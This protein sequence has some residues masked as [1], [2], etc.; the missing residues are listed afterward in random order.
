MRKQLPLKLNS[1]MS[2]L[3]TIKRTG[4]FSG[5]HCFVRANRFI[6]A[7]VTG[8]LTCSVAA[9]PVTDN[10]DILAR[11][12]NAFENASYDGV[13]VYSQGQDVKTL[14][15]IHKVKDGVEKERLIH[16]DG[17]RFE[18][19]RD[20]EKLSCVLPKTADG[21]VEHKVPPS[22]F[23]QSFTSNIPELK[24][25]YYI[26]EDRK[27]RFLGRETVRLSILPKQADRYSYQLWID[28]T[29]GLMLKSVLKNLSGDELERFQFSS[30]EIGKPIP[31]YLFMVEDLSQ[32][33]VVNIPK[34][35][36]AR[37]RLENKGWRVDWIPGGFSSVMND[38][39]EMTS[40][41]MGALEYMKAYSDGLFSFSVLVEKIESSTD[42]DG[43][44]TVG[45]T[46]VMRRKFTDLNNHYRVTVVGEIPVATVKRILTSV[47]Q[48]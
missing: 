31:D 46:T 40:P 11:M 16:L 47:V 38:E 24:K 36:P 2:E 29:S 25:N 13:F 35:T 7:A 12:S 18:L 10:A 19:L 9:D 26:R 17:N 37:K 28:K 42:G 41:V 33:K 8:M 27:Q 4:F 22:S 39:I 21:P 32:V 23:A 3:R 14:R 1:S 45:A 15:V 20:G 48:E 30:L 6:L 34:K 44:T 5:K 43:L